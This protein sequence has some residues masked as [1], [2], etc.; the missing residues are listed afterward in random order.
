M[1]R[2]ASIRRFIAMPLLEREAPLTEA[3]RLSVTA[4][5]ESEQAKEVAAIR[6]FG[7]V[8][9]RARADWSIYVDRASRHLDVIGWVSA[10]LHNRAQT[11]P[12]PFRSEQDQYLYLFTAKSWHL[13]RAPRG[14]T[15]ELLQHASRLVWWCGGE[16]IKAHSGVPATPAPLP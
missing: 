5:R 13:G 4:Q 6:D 12:T 11:D 3:E 2:L 14:V 10:A 1:T 16:G 9:K 15:C 7:Q 8:Y